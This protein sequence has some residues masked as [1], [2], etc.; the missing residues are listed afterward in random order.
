[1]C[2]CGTAGDDAFAIVENLPC[3]DAFRKGLA[4]AYPVR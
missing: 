2:E 3:K 1:M 4:V